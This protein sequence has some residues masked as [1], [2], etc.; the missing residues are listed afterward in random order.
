MRI[1]MDDGIDLTVERHGAG[2]PV[3]LVHGFGGAK[4]DFADHVPAL[5]EHAT[6]VIFD[7]RGH[8]SSDHPADEAA[9]SLD[10]LAA[11]TVGVATAL[12][13]DHFRLLGH[14]MGGMVARRVVLARPDAVDGLVLMDTSPGPPPGIDPATVD[15]GIEIA[16]RD[17]MAVLKAMQDELD[18]L[19]TAAHRRLLAERPGYREFGDRKWEALSQAMWVALVA[20]IVRQPDQLDALTAVRCPTLVVVGEQD[21][22]F[23]G[24]SAATAA[25][26][27]GAQLVTIP[28]A[29]H[30][31]QFEN[32]PVWF[33][34]LDG[35]L[36]AD[37]RELA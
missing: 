32:P 37:A 12:G 7:H 8:G 26:I 28:D 13:F 23:L 9:Y 1:T 31:P 35:F 34:A 18:L 21:T 33:D 17:G 2:P 4:E 14:S 6:V 19:G 30:S 11:D 5:A 36:R 15:L 27:P 20:E 22:P 25:V 10:R 16:R 29:G 3:L 24:A